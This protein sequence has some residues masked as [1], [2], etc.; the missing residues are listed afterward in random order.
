M[1]VHTFELTLT[2]ASQPAEGEV[3]VPTEGVSDTLVPIQ[4]SPEVW[5][6][7]HVPVEGV[8][9]LAAFPQIRIEPV[10][11]DPLHLSVKASAVAAEKKVA[12]RVY[13]LGR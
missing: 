9:D 2:S 8:A 4:G 7:W 3:I 13:V 6:V 10:P 1:Q 5:A 12:L 11:G